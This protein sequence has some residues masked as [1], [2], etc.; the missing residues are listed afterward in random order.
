METTRVAASS[1]SC[2]KDVAP[3]RSGYC[4]CALLN[5]FVESATIQDEHLGPR[6]RVAHSWCGHRPFKCRD[7][8]QRPPRRQC[9]GF[10]SMDSCQPLEPG[11]ADPTR[12]GNEWE[13]RGRR[14]LASSMHLTNHTRRQL[15]VS[16]PFSSAPTKNNKKRARREARRHDGGWSFLTSTTWKCDPSASSALASASASSSLHRQDRVI[17]AIIHSCPA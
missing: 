7:V 6:Y 17:G 8:C 14:L 13:G 9:R 2:D 3:G 5:V 4:E 11:M 15:S 1:S 16:F 12:G 10:S